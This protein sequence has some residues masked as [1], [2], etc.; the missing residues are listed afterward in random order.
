MSDELA[1]HYR[2]ARVRVSELA[3]SL[4]AEAQATRVPACPGWTIRDLLAHVVALPEDALA[5]RLH[6]PPDDDFTAG[7][8]ERLSGTASELVAAWAVTGPQIEELLAGG[9]P[10]PALVIDLH[11]HEQDILGALGRTGARDLPG[12][13]WAIGSVL[14]RFPADIPAEPW[15]AWRARLGRRSRAQVEAWDWPADT[16]LSDFFIFGPRGTDLVE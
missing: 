6:G 8:V 5:G 12:T 11:T 15:E 14:D 16:D 9:L 2:S 4:D 7:Q 10:A 3:C 13:R 1:E